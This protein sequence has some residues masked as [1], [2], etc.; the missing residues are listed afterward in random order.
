[1]ASFTIQVHNLRFFAHHGVYE[2]EKVLGNE[3]E[4]NISLKVKARAETVSSIHQTVNYADVYRITKEIFSIP[5]PLLETVAQNI[6]EAIKNKHSSV[7]KISVQIIKLHPPIVSFIG[8][9][10]VTFEK[11]YD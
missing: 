9:V 6:A 2:E 10:S 11:R 4:V 5:Q 7:K 3:F 1:M 8:A